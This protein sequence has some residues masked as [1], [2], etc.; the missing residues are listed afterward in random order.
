MF[1]LNPAD[2]VKQTRYQLA[3][4]IHSRMV[5]DG[6]QSPPS[7]DELL[8]SQ[9]PRYLVDHP[10]VDIA[11][12]AQPSPDEFRELHR[13]MERIPHDAEKTTICQV[14]QNVFNDNVI[15]WG[16]LS[17]IFYFAYKMSVRDQYNVA[18]IRCI[19]EAVVES[20]KD[21]VTQWIIDNGGW[22][23]VAAMFAPIRVYAMVKDRLK[24]CSKHMLFVLGAGGA[25]CG[26]VYLWNR[27]KE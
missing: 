1:H 23:Q 9:Y 20:K 16:R 11:K 3:T 19:I 14:I 7:V 17:A 6:I 8:D 5:E 13:I 21:E 10:F 2:V 26:I 12:T 24:H 22:D 18:R 27:M 25:V 15:S 4:Y